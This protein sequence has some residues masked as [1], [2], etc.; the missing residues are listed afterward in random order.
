MQ[1]EVYPTQFT[2]HKSEIVGGGSFQNAPKTS[3]KVYTGNER[4]PYMDEQVCEALKTENLARY[5]FKPSEN[6]KL[7]N[8]KVLIISLT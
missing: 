7:Y 6:P 5:T 1:N 2:R 8:K 4:K 3:W